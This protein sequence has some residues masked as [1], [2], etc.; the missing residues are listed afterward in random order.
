MAAE[1]LSDHFETLQLHAGYV[2]LLNFHKEYF[3]VLGADYIVDKRLTRQR[4]LALSPSTRLLY[5]PQ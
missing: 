3:G 1:K 2:T 4:N 5:V